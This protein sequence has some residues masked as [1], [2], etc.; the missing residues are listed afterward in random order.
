MRATGYYNDN[1]FPLEGERYQ[2]TTEYRRGNVVQG[3]RQEDAYDGG[4]QFREWKRSVLLSMGE[5]GLEG[6]LKTVNEHYVMVHEA[7]V[8][9]IRLGVGRCLSICGCGRRCMGMRRKRKSL[10]RRGV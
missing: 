7:N 3:V 4:G 9:A 8:A 10:K 1:T 2:V 6:A 5:K